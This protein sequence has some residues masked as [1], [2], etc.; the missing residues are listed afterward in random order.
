MA[1]MLARIDLQGLALGRGVG[2]GHH[3]GRWRGEVH[4]DQL[5]GRGVGQVDHDPRQLRVVGRAGRPGVD[6]VD[7]RH[8]LDNRAGITGSNRCK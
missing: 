7:L 4:A 6:R 8:R 3:T 5:Q 2:H 1:K